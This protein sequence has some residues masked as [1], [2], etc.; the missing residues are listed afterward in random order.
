MGISD[1]R[2]FTRLATQ[3]TCGVTRIVEGVHQNVWSS[4]GF[5]SGEGPGET[6]GFTRMI[7]RTINGTTQW[8]G[9]SAD[10]A[11]AG[12]QR[13]LDSEDGIAPE[14]PRRRTFLS[15]VNGVI[16]DHL[17]NDNNPFAVPMT[18]TP[19]ASVPIQ[20]ASGKVLLLIHGLCMN[21]LE[22]HARHNHYELEYGQLLAGKLGYD[23]VYLRYNSGLHVS[24]NGRELAARLEKWLE[25]WPAEVVDLSVLAHSMGGLLIRSAVHYAK[26][27][28]LNWPERL[29]NIVFLGTPHHGA[30]LERVGNWLDLVLDSIPHT[31]PF[32]ALAKVRSAGVTDLRYGNV[33][34]EDWHG[35]NR[36]ELNPDERSIAPLPHTANCYSVAAT[37]A[38]SRNA[39]A[40]HVVGDGLVPLHSALGRHK[41]PARTLGFDEESQFIV[42]NTNHMSLL[43][44]R[45]VSEQVVEWL[46]PGQAGR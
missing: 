37:L 8:V 28:G 31:R 5:P 9:K 16:G 19:Q 40:D 46:S 12:L 2:G 41:S 34:E 10:I 15:V 27:E 36:F 32:T 35:R 20:K 42:Y 44:S 14:S 4:M 17:V 26:Q 3:A 38:K 1:W 21:D 24:Q 30:P 45:E 22:Q 6:R 39:L 29:K 18:L 7:Y 23:P 13:V 33:L 43:N 25:H 11:L